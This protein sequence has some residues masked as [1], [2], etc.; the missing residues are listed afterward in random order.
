MKNK[1]DGKKS[2]KKKDKKKDKKAVIVVTEN[3]AITEAPAS[4]EGL[5]QPK[6][7]SSNYNVQDALAK[8]RELKTKEEI[9]SFT[10]GESRVTLIRAIPA[11][12][13]RLT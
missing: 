11:V 5:E 13:N 7:L 4:R 1:A 12:L 3:T 10:K 2:S 9:L 8:L 6:D